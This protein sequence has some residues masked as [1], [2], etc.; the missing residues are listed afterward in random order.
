M[1]HQRSSR[2]VVHVKFDSPMYRN[3]LPVHIPLGVLRVTVWCFRFRRARMPI[4][5]CA[6]YSGVG[7]SVP[8]SGVLGTPKVGRSSWDLLMC[9]NSRRLQDMPATGTVHWLFK[10]GLLPERE[11]NSTFNEMQFRIHCCNRYPSLIIV[12]QSV[13][14]YY[15]L[16]CWKLK[17]QSL[18]FENKNIIF[19]FHMHYVF[20][21][22]EH[23]LFLTW[24]FSNLDIFWNKRL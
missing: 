9:G 15:K 11:S 21:F 22:G 14:N 17:K 8:Q 1:S 23:I 6:P 24:Q 4:H 12:S 10:F 5:P 3:L 2:R 18:N 7:H 13:G 19:T 16:L 20:N